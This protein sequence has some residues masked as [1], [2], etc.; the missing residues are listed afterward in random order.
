VLHGGAR[1]SYTPIHACHKLRQPLIQNPNN[2][3]RAH[4]MTAPALGRQFRSLR[5]LANMWR[6][7]SHACRPD[8]SCVCPDQQTPYL[9]YNFISPAKHPPDISK[10]HATGATLT[11]RVHLPHRLHFLPATPP[12][13]RVVGNMITSSHANAVMKAGETKPCCVVHL[14]P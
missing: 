11:V 10:R 2:S 3:S 4:I 6:L 8:T 9:P 13:P 1:L 7:H 5:A 14:P 12:I